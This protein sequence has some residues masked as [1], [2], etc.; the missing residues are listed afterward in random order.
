[1]TPYLHE[2]YSLILEKSGIWRKLADD[3]WNNPELGD[4]EVFACAEQV[5]LLNELGF[6][7]EAPYCDLNTAY[8]AE[9]GSGTPVFAFAAEYDALPGVGHGCGHNLICTAGI[10]A[11]Y[12][13]MTLLKKY[14]LPGRI[15]LLGTPAEEGGGGKVRMQEKGCLDGIGA[16]MMVHPSWR[17]VPDTGS[18]A[19][20]CFQVDFAGQAAHAAGSPELGLNALDGVIL[21]FNALNAYRQHLPETSRMHGVISAGGEVPNVIPAHAS[22][23][24]YLRALDEEWIEKMESRFRDIVRGAELMTGTAAKI[25][26]TEAPY[27]SRKPNPEMNAVYMEAAE[28]LG[29]N[30][31]VPS[32]TGRGSSDFGNFSQ[33]IP[34]IHPYFG[35]TDRETASHSLE[36]AEAAHSDYGFDQSMR[37]AA[38]MALT[39][40]RYLTEEDLRRKIHSAF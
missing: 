13:V 7:V 24:V 28:E 27:K 20:R 39:G 19:L 9:W 31:Y 8:R 14:H 4:Q 38:A 32:K 21:V 10:A 5:R 40:L 35:I 12:A 6:R 17:T 15:V 23:E 30:P 37:A 36:F 3:I 26:L 25:T 11:A 34:G 33:V 29:M 18:T 22:C 1:M 2:L 16:V